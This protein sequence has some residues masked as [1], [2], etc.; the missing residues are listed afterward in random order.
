MIHD[1]EVEEVKN[2]I[3]G[4]MNKS[5][6]IIDSMTTHY[7]N[8]NTSVSRCNGSDF[9]KLFEGLKDHQTF[10][11]RA[12][13]SGCGSS[14]FNLNNPRV[15]ISESESSYEEDYHFTGKQGIAVNT[16]IYMC[17]PK[18]A[19]YWEGLIGFMPLLY[20]YLADGS[21]ILEGRISEVKSVG[22]WQHLVSV[23]PLK[24]RDF[25]MGEWL[26]YSL[27]DLLKLI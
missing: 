25:N 21:W 24:Y 5:D 2:L 15:I 16:R 12:K 27:S 3:I 8:K 26:R 7:I 22:G 19:G 17:T 4:L 20:T 9:G 18:R 6:T 23:H 11:A 10:H 14:Y 1:I 13:K